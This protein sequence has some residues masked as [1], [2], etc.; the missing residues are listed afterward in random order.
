MGGMTGHRN[1]PLEK[2]ALALLALA[3]V[4]GF[5][6]SAP[7]ILRSPFDKAMSEAYMS[8]DT[9]VVGDGRALGGVVPHHDIAVEMM[10]RFYGHFDKNRVK[11]IFILAPD[12]F[13]RARR[14][15]AV[16]PDDWELSSG[17]IR[18]D[19]EAA[20]ALGKL[21]FVDTRPD[22]FAGEHGVTVHIPLLAEFFPRASVVPIVFGPNI[23]DTAILSL[24]NALRSVMRDG[25]IVILSADLSHYKTPE[26]MAT[27]DERTI[28]ALANMDAAALNSADIDARKAAAL[29]LLLMKDMGA[30]SGRLLERSDTSDILGYRIESGT[31]Y[32]T[33][34]YLRGE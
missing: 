27:E 16:C 12:H 20:E 13:G 30:R 34:I 6:S 7:A 3:C 2:T 23:P 14:P 25:D 22:L 26:A 32:A 4:F 28:R 11:R 9:A 1:A 19:G 5:P 18:A 17:T 29:A 15:V 10:T 21:S 33:I 31:S 24:R 8:R